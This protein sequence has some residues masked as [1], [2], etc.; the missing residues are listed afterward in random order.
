M[1]LPQSDAHEAT[2]FDPLDREA[3][4]RHEFR[5]QAT[6]GPDEANCATPCAQFPRHGQ[7][8]HHVTA[9]ASP[10]HYESCTHPSCSLTLSSIPRQVIVL[11]K[12][13][14]PRLIIGRG[15]PLVGPISSTTLM[16]MNAWTTIATVTPSR[17][18][19]RR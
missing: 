11:S 1:S 15:N 17:S 8:G 18:E 5:F 13:L 19:E 7:G 9:G 3:V 16:F 10:R 6:A 2:N 4:R 12:E 14:P